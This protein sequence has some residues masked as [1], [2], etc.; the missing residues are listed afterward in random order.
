MGT[1]GFFGWLGE[2]LG[3]AIR[4][5]VDLL[6]GLLGGIW[7]AMDDF[8]HGLARAIGMDTSLFS[9][10]VLFIGLML[11]VSGIRALARKGI[12]SGL[13][14]TLL[15]LVVVSWLIH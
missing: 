6:S 4:F 8:F 11:L 9:F 13:I 7:S 2:A 5:I 14:L 3:R 10:V 12:I 1:E 15:G